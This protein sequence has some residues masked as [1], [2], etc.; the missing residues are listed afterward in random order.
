MKISIIIFTGLF[1]SACAYRWEI[2]VP[3]E[4]QR[5][6]HVPVRGD[7]NSWSIDFGQFHAYDIFDRENRVLMT[8]YKDLSYN[9]KIFEFTIEDAV[10]YKWNCWCEFPLRSAWEEKIRFN[11]QDL[12]NPTYKWEMKDTVVTQLDNRLVVASYFKA[13]KKRLLGQVLMGYTMTY[14]DRLVGLVDVANTNEESFYVLPDITPEIQMLVA[15]TGTALILKQRKW[16]QYQNEI[17]AQQM[18]TQF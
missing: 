14:N 18:E 7:E 15:A 3:V 2:D 5:A 11:L 17:E 8:D 12:R 16:Y 1:L 10:G 13:K 6:I 4:L 9:V